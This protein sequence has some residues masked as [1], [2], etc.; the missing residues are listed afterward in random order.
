MRVRWTR[1]ARRNLAQAVDYIAKDNPDA[2]TGIAKQILMAAQ[3]LEQHPLLGRP[4]RL[5][6]T[7]ELVVPRLSFVIRYRITGEAIQ[8]IRIHHTAR[9]WP[10]EK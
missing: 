4:G 1:G 9:R 3:M 6:G 5:K 7:R 2:G 10:E 8:L